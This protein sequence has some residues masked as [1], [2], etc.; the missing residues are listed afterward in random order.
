MNASFKCTFPN[1]ETAERCAFEVRNRLLTRVSIY[2]DCD[3]PYR[4][5]FTNVTGAV[6]P[7][8]FSLDGNNTNE[9]AFAFPV[10]LDPSQQYHSHTPCKITMRITGA[11]EDIK[12]AEEIAINFGALEKRT[13]GQ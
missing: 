7:A 3:Y 6:F 12:A 9:E 13:S 1:V 4:A 10:L 11:A 8:N 5:D 2:I